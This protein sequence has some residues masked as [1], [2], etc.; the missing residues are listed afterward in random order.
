[1]GDSLKNVLLYGAGTQSTGLLLMAL[2]G[3]LAVPDLT[4][5]ADTHSEP[6][7][8]YKYL[9]KVGKYVKEKFNYDITVVFSGVYEAELKQLTQFP[10]RRVA[11]LPLFTANGGMIRRQCTHEYK[12]QPITKYIKNKYL[13]TRKKKHSLPIIN[14]WF[15]MSLDEIERCRISQDWWAENRYPLIESRMYRHEVIN[16]INT[17]HPKLKN[18]PRSSCYFCPFHTD[19]YWRKLKEKHLGE[20]KKACEIDETVRTNPKLKEKCYLHRSLKPLNKIDFEKHQ[21]EIFGECE[22]YCGI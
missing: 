2:D 16:Y 18:P 19:N 22:G 10:L 6:A 3:N 1:M 21:L 7:F 12:I 4:I 11:S 17:N 13:I 9:K 8:V 14:R 15:G 20:F 5:F